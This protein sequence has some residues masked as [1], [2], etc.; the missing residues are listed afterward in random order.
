MHALAPAALAHIAL[1]HIKR[2]PVVIGLGEVLIYLLADKRHH[3]R[4]QFRQRNQ[5]LVQRG[6]SAKLIRVAAPAR[7]YPRLP[8]PPPAAPHIPVGH[9]LDQPLHAARRPVR[10]KPLH[11]VRELRH[12]LVQLRQDPPIQLGALSHRR[13]RRGRIIAVYVRV[14]HEERVHIPQRD[15]ELPPNL[16]RRAKAEVDVVR[17]IHPQKHPPHS[18][19]AHLLRRILKPDRI[20]LALVHLL[21]VFVAHQR[22]AEHR[23]ERRGIPQHRGHRQQ[24]VE[25]V[26]ELPRKALRNPIRRKPLA[27]VSLIMPILQRRERHYPRVKPGVPHIRYPRHLDAAL[28]AAYLHRVHPGPMRRIA[29]ELI[30]ALYRAL[31]QLSLAA[32]HIEPA[33]I[34]A[35]V[36]RQRQPVVALLGNH[37]IVH[38]AEPVQLPRI[39]ELRLPADSVHHIH[40]L[41]AQACRLFFVRNLIARLVMLSPHADEPLIH[42]PEHQLRIAAPAHRIA[43]RIRLHPIEDAFR[44]QAVI[45]RV[46]DLIDILPREPIEPG[47][48]IAELVQRRDG[49]NVVFLPQREVFAARARRDMH[50]PR[51]LAL[52]HLIPRHD[53]VLHP[54]LRRQ[55]RERRLIAQ[56]DKRARRHFP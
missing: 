34:A 43:M 26:A 5:A 40:Y 7:Q 51:P 4:N 35:L 41:V 22:V 21:A 15:Y 52:A 53:P 24:R 9:I 45:N 36:Y 37:P 46:I 6:V 32:Y 55:L 19:N 48:E 14:R 20:A 16:V 18:V 49:G 44:L 39:P 10:L 30:P 42:Q 8:E 3:R 2:K 29:R 54:I 56:P 33:A 31:L 17:R 50:N 28:I 13:R 47:H 12:H 38:I 23:P 1:A 11:C 25:P 27:P